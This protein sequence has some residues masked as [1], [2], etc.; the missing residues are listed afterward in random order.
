MTPPTERDGG[1][2]FAHG[3]PTNGGDPGMS[4]RDYFAIHISPREVNEYIA[5][6]AWDPGDPPT[7]AEARYALADLLLSAREEG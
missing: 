7:T 1:P 5:E 2:A 3:D 4:L 6:R